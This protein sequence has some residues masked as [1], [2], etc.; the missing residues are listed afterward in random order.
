VIGAKIIAKTGVLGYLPE[1]R[2]HRV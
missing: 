1:S 2:G